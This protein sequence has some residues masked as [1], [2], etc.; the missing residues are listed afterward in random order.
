MGIGFLAFVATNVDDLLLLVL[1]F[2]LTNSNFKKRHVIIGQYLGFF[3][4]ITV[5]LLGSFCKWIVPL[6]WIGFLGWVPIVLGVASVVKSVKLRRKRSLSLPI[7]IRVCNTSANHD[8]EMRGLLWGLKLIYKIQHFQP[9]VSPS[10]CTVFEPLLCPQVYSVVAMTVGD[11]V[12]NVATYIPLFAAGDLMR[13]GILIGFFLLLVGLWCYIGYTLV[14]F[15]IVADVAERLGHIL[16]PFVF[17]LLGIV[18]MIKTG[19]LVL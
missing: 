14:S 12:D 9:D 10:F 7:P 17:I 8:N 1:L 15:R 19:L 11:G 18:I 13:M 6:K 3:V 4:I 5:S 16:L 2:S